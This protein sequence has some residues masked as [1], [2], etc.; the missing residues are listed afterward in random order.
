MPTT[1]ANPTAYYRLAALRAVRDGADVYSWSLA[2]ALRKV[3]AKRPS[4]IDIT[5]PKMY[6][7]DGTDRVPYFGAIAT[8]QGVEAVRDIHE[9][10]W[11]ELTHAER[12]TAAR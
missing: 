12:A 8:P 1:F 3:E 10:A 11:D 7:G 4:L 9:G 6:D 5:E 2:G